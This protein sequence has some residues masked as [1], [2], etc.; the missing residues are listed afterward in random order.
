MFIRGE[1]KKSCTNRHASFSSCNRSQEYF[2]PFLKPRDKPKVSQRNLC[3]LLEIHVLKNLFSWIVGVWYWK[4]AILSTA[5]R[6]YHDE[7]IWPIRAW[8]Q[9]LVT[10]NSGV[11]GMSP[12]SPPFPPPQNKLLGSLCLRIFFLFVFSFFPHC[13]A[14][15][16]ANVP[17]VS[18]VWISGP[19]YFQ[20]IMCMNY[21]SPSTPPFLKSYM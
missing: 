15:S 11:K 2:L 12:G 6:R 18:L 10:R 19:Y 17:V 1:Y 5:P 16:Q 3:C 9:N 20:I 14:W 7:D 21:H 13:G 8:S 4:S